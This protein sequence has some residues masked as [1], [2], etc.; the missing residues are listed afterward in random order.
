MADWAFQET[1]GCQDCL[2]GRVR[3]GRWAFPALVSQADLDFVGQKATQELLASQ[4]NLV[5][6]VLQVC[7]C[8]GIILVPDCQQA[9]QTPFLDLG[10]LQEL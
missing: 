3:Q 6:Q 10:V 8:T 4:G 9:R 2:V 1:G 7:F 5:P